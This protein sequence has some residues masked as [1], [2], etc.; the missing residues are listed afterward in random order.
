MFTPYFP[1][2]LQTAF[3]LSEKES[4]TLEEIYSN[5]P[6]FKKMREAVK[7][8][9]DVKELFVQNIIPISISY[10]KEHM[11]GAMSVRD[12]YFEALDSLENI[13]LKNVLDFIQSSD[14]LFNESSV[15]NEV[16]VTTVHKSKGR[17]MIMLFIYQ[18]KQEIHLTF[19]IESLEAILKTHGINASEELEEEALRIDFV[20]FTRAKNCLYVLTDKT[21]DYLDENSEINSINVENIDAFDLFEKG[22][23]AYGIFLEGNFEK[24]KELLENND[25]WIND[26]IKNHFKNLDRISF[27]SLQSNAYEYLTNNILRLREFSY[28]T[29]LGTKVH[30]IAEALAKG[31]KI[32]VREELIPY[33]NNILEILKEVKKVI[34]FLLKQNAD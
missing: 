33:K 19:K 30:S 2:K 29:N 26:Y 18:R 13:S 1:L 14:L 32:D 8:I 20:A 6:E 23:R 22:K 27:S 10:G 16:V 24:A 15:E 31:E 12:A 9:E 25:R 3:P 4:L 17:N 7:T 11:L 5:C 34:Q 28:A 21:E